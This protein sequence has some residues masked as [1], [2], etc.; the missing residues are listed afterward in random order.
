[1]TLRATY[2]APD[3]GRYRSPGGAWDVPVLDSVMRQRPPGSGAV[4][5]DGDCRFD[6]PQLEALVAG[7]AG[8]LRR[9][10]VRRGDVVTW[11]MP[12]WWEALVLY[13]A[14]WRCGAVAAPLHHQFGAAEVE[15]MVELLAPKVAFSSPV[16]PLAERDG[17]ICVRSTGSRFDEMVKANPVR[18]NAH[19]GASTNRP[20]D[21]AAVIFTSGSTGRPKAVLHTHRGLAYKA[22][23]M[24]AVHGLSSADSVLMPAPLAHISGLLNAV[25]VPGAAAMRTVLM[26]RWDVGRGLSLMEKERISYMIGPP[27]MFTSLMEDSSFTPD[28]VASMRVISSGMMGVSPAFI[29]AAREG[30]G[31]IVK[32]SYGSTEAPTVSTCT[33]DDPPERCQE[34]DGRAVGDAVIRITD[35]LTGRARRAGKEGEVWIRGPELFAGYSDATETAASMQRG[36]FRSGDLGVL[37]AQGW[38]T[39]TGRIKELIIRGGENISSSE[40]ERT[41]ELHPGIKQAVVV[42]RPDDRLGERVVAFVVGAGPGSGVIDVAEC[43]RWFVEH[44]MARFKTPEFVVQLDAVPLLAAG[45]PD[46]TALKA[47]AATLRMAV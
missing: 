9:M 21:L 32:R 41:L 4:L 39:I 19:G 34:T 28:K 12:N 24:T 16:L 7:L 8:G 1:L 37:D 47:R 36:W 14:C 18:A 15:Y 10:G 11:Q 31:A 27:T 30:L 22:Q 38:L 17:T 40:V 26:D 3:A 45:K 33:N 25:L 13:R 6:G 43:R 46:R 42:G 5:V 35:P 29:A 44:G 20:A 2:R 23:K